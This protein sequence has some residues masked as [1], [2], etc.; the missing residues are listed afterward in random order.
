MDSPDAAGSGPGL[1]D[2]AGA[3][4]AF[5]RPPAG[6][7]RGLRG[8]RAGREPGGCWVGADAGPGGALGQLFGWLPPGAD[9]PGPF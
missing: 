6:G 7:A 2:P 5:P 8:P 1:G 4:P 9:S 3:R